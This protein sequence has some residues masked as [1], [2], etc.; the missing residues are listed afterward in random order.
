[1]K[2]EIK[3]RAATPNDAI[4]VAPLIIQAMEDLAAKFVGSQDPY[5][6]IPLF[7]HFFKN[8]ENQYSHAH[9]I[10]AELDN[11]IVGSVVGYDGGSLQAYR[12]PFFDYVLANYQQDFKNHNFG[13][14]T[15]AN[16]FYIDTVSVSSKHQGYGIGSKLINA[17]IEKATNEKHKKVGLLVDI[18]NPNAKKL[19]TR[20]G[21]TVEGKKNLAGHPYEHLQYTTNR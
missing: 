16:E 8:T 18:D 13:D 2:K 10:V 12:A 9:C 15:Q 17:I 6:A 21:F 19:Y 20:L 14:E 4:Q 11:T 3:L 5:D 7:T 1:M